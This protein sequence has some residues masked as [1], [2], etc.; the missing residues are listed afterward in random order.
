MNRWQRYW[1]ADGGRWGA[2]IVRIAI[3]SAVLLTLSRLSTQDPL[4]APAEL[5]R[6]VGIW[7]LLGH[8]VPP[9]ALISL[10][11]VVAWGGSV[12]MLVGLGTR[13]ATAVSFGASI[14]LAA[15]SF[16]NSAT[17]SHQYNVVFLAQCAFLGARGG[18]VLSLDAL[19]RRRRGLAAIDAPRGYQW[20]LRLVQLAV[21]L[22]FAGAVFHKILHGHGTLRWALSDNLRHHL[23]VRYDLAGLD[24][25]PLVDWIIDDVWKYRTAALLNLVTQLV[26]ILACVFV[27]RPWVRAACGAAF[28]TET[29]A[30]GFVISLWNPHWLPLV[31]VFIDW[32]R[33]LRRPPPP[34]PPTAWK[35]PRAPQI[36]IAVFVGYEL[37]TSFIPT[38]DQRLNTFPFSSFP[39]FATIRAEAPYGEHHDYTVVGDHIEPIGNT[40]HMFAQRWLDH[41]FRGLYLERD[42]ERLK[43]RLA[44]IL[45]QAPSRYPDA[46]IKGLRSYLTLFVAPAYPAPAH[47]EPHLIAVTGELH[48]DGSFRTLMGSLRGN[49]LELRPRGIDTSSVR[50]V[51]YRDDEPTPIDLAAPRTGDRFELPALPGSPLYVVAIVDGTPW[52]AAS[53]K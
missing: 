26:P 13:A 21:A 36:F 46:T 2:A 50:L 45:E 31:A 39:M 51:Y 38:L 44:Q 35:P 17:W 8:T 9:D 20:S 3:A 19:I 1:F 16:S 14:A 33:L 22:M 5:Y 53:R 18:D 7:M 49:T 52:L 23:L 48:P 37:L 43:A 32:D 34:E 10:L 27:R 28:V 30:L 4:V 41:A 6:P 12:C 11:W 15:I 42:P 40:V 47:F 24:R 25:P 29:L